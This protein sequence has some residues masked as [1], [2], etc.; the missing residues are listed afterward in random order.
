MGGKKGGLYGRGGKGG[1]GMEGEVK[2]W[3][4]VQVVYITWEHVTVPVP[5][6]AHPSRP[7]SPVSQ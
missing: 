6:T 4:R 3:R 2:G 1:W 5:P 7:S